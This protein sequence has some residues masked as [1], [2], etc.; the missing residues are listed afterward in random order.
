M[1]SAWCALDE[2]EEEEEEEERK[3]G[4]EMGVADRPRGG[5]EVAKGFRGGAMAELAEGR[6]GCECEWPALV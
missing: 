4:F 2:E 6:D 3:S 1:G 5:L